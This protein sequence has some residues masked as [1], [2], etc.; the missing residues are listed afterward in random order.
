MPSNGVQE[1]ANRL[2]Q[3]FEST[4]AN[5]YAK[6][7]PLTV[8]DTRLSRRIRFLAADGVQTIFSYAR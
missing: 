8:L 5:A 1:M 2:R 4:V 6:S 3:D 7:P